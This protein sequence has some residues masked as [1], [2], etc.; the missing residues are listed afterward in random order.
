MLAVSLFLFYSGATLTSNN[1]LF[2]I[3]SGF[4]F[5]TDQPVMGTI[6][7]TECMPRVVA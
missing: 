1:I 6:F 3:V 4:I 7:K 2:E 5:S